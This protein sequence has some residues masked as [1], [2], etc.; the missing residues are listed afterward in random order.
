MADIELLVHEEITRILVELGM[1]PNL[2]GFR[3]LHQCVY[4][5]SKN[6]NM[7]KK[8]TKNLYPTVGKIY[9]MEGYVV[10]RCM[11]HVTE[12]GFEKTGFKALCDLYGV[13][14]N[15]WE[16]KPTSS[17]LIALLAEYIRIFLQK[18][19]REQKKEKS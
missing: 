3:C 5:V 14:E 19:S 18:H 2:Q 12:I 15:H 7:I 10:E 4:E 9:D 13:E 11:R 1:S 16:Y 8:V 17:E 6:P